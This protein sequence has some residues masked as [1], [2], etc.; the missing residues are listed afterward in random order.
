MDYENV[1]NYCKH[2]AHCGHTC[3]DESCDHCTE[4]GCIK[5][6]INHEEQDNIVM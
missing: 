4:C 6:D 1:C 5:C 2:E 3:L